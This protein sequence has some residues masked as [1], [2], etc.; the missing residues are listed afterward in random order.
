MEVTYYKYYHNRIGNNV[1]QNN[2]KDGSTMHSG[3]KIVLRCIALCSQSLSIV[4]INKPHIRQYFKCL[5]L[6]PKDDV[7]H[8]LP[9]LC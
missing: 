9:G 3:T 5:A 7:I 6:T 1:G 4:D 2:P 8:T